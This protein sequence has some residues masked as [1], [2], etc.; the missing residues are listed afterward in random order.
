MT[1][2]SSQQLLQSEFLLRYITFEPWPQLLCGIDPVMVKHPE[3]KIT[4]VYNHWAAVVDWTA[5][6]YKA[7]GG[8]GAL[9][10][11]SKIC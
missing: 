1:F 7:W 9:G 10:W 11:A 5:Y 2:L 6:S 8:G 4:A 3:H